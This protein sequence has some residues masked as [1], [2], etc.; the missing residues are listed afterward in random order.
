MS[1]TT[2]WA[3]NS[4]RKF[5]IGAGVLLFYLAYL[6]IVSVLMRPTLEAIRPLL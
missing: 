3:R 5:L 6:A 4:A 2:Q 1:S